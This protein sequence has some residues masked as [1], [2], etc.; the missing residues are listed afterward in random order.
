MN[1]DEFAQA[2]SL[3]ADL[4]DRVADMAERMNASEAFLMGQTLAM[5]TCIQALLIGTDPIKAPHLQGLLQQLAEQQRQGLP[6]GAERYYDLVLEDAQ[7]ALGIA[8]AR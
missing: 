3:V 2:M 4:A 1:E 5:R 8:A 6:P 7:S